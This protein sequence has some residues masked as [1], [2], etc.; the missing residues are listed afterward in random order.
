MDCDMVATQNIDELFCIDTFACGKIVFPPCEGS[1]SKL[2]SGMLVVHPDKPTF[3]DM[4]SRYA[5][6]KSYN[7]GDQVG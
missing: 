1:C 7:S 2:N 5:T 4:F 3:D 6:T